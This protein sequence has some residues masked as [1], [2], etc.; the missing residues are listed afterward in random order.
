[1]LS[2][3]GHALTM[4]LTATGQAEFER[5]CDR[6]VQAGAASSCHMGCH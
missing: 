5:P 3:P 2:S 4:A 1:M 6:P